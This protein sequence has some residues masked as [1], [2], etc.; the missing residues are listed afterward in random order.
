MFGGPS[1]SFRGP[2]SSEVATPHRGASQA[3]FF[4][5]FW[6]LKSRDIPQKQHWIIRHHIQVVMCQSHIWLPKFY[7]RVIWLRGLL[8]ECWGPSYIWCQ[9]I[10]C[11]DPTENRV[12]WG[13]F[14][15]WMVFSCVRM[16]SRGHRSADLQLFVHFFQDCLSINS[17]LD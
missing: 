16:A 3:L 6:W 9:V 14:H 12:D 7:P 5:I 8:I 13:A 17:M 11:L 15:R 1:P 10:S 2:C 4:G